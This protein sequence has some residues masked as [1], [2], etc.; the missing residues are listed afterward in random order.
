[1]ALRT[2]LTA[3]DNPY[4]LRQSWHGCFIIFSGIQRAIL[5]SRGTGA[6]HA[7]VGH[8]PNVPEQGLLVASLP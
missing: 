8:H 1:M 2:R 3:S 6:R 4:E 5:G 7:A